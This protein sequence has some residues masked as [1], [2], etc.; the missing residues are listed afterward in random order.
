MKTSIDNYRLFRLGYLCN[1]QQ[2]PLLLAAFIY[3]ATNIT[4]AAFIFL[5]T[6]SGLVLIGLPDFYQHMATGVIMLMAV[7]FQT[8]HRKS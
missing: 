2:D 4:S 1:G 3:V 6:G 7:L 8:Q 5:A